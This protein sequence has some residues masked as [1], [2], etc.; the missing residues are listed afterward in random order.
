[1]SFAI[2]VQGVQ[3]LVVLLVHV[4][5]YAAQVGPAMRDNDFTFGF[6]AEQLVHIFINMG[7]A[8]LQEN[9]LGSDEVVALLVSNVHHG[10]LNIFLYGLLALKK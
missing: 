7:V 3:P 4:V 1:M 9:A 6:L 5:L 2:V 10:L 8:G